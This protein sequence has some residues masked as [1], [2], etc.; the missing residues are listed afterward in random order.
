MAHNFWPLKM[1]REKLWMVLTNS[2]AV[3]GLVSNESVVH[4]TIILERTRLY[5]EI[6]EK[7]LETDEDLNATTTA[8]EAIIPELETM[9]MREEKMADL[10]R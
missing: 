4:L 1:K 3:D 10:Y 8:Q 5:F 2:L 7:A 6:L 9:K